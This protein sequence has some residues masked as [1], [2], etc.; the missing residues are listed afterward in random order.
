MKLINRFVFSW[1]II[2]LFCSMPIFG[3]IT[4]TSFAVLNEIEVN[5]P[6]TDEEACEYVEI[7]GDPSTAFP[8]LLYL[9][10]LEGDGQDA[11]TADFVL[12][13][14]N[15]QIGANGIFTFTGGGVTPMITGKRPNS[16]NGSLIAC[17]NRN[18]FAGG[19]NV[20]QEDNRTFEN[21]TISFLLI[22][23]FGSTIIQDA[24]YD[25]DN[26]G[27]LELPQDAV[28]VDAVGWTDGGALDFVYGGVN[29]TPGTGTPDAATRNFSSVTPLNAASWF[30]DDLVGTGVDA[31][32]YSQTNL[33]GYRIDFITPGRQNL[34]PAAAA[35]SISGRVLNDRGS[36]L[37]FVTVMIYGGSLGEPRY[38]TT[39]QFGYFRFEDVPFGDSYILQVF[40]RRY[41][42]EQSTRVFNFSEDITNLNFIG[43]ERY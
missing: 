17:G 12:E 20:V 40:S 38:A 37:K 33:G 3:Q 18:Y 5:N 26:N 11:G 34:A 32:L 29:I 31:D 22:A 41:T 27:V 25:A 2:I 16:D 4:T 28:I 39:N 35:G 7:R 23:T 6:G 8:P 43:S 9:V 19:A 13:L 24:D 30:A 21:G 42:F 15:R 14:S 36:G 10:E 1:A